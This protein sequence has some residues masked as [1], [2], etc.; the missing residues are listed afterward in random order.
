[1]PGSLYFLFHLIL[2]TLTT[3]G[4]FILL[5]GVLAI[6]CLSNPIRGGKQ[7]FESMSNYQTSSSKPHFKTGPKQ[8][9]SDTHTK[10]RRVGSDYSNLY[11]AWSSDRTAPLPC[12]HV[13]TK[14]SQIISCLH[15]H[16]CGYNLIFKLRKQI[17]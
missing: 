11:R 16:D 13:K 3:A 9:L 5:S 6:I 2:I 4:I 7:G 14:R 15:V 1:M 17:H 12:N 10:S 8:K